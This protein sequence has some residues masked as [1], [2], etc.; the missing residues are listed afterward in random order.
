VESAVSV[1]FLS[2]IDCVCEECLAVLNL[3]W[4]VDEEIGFL[5]F[6]PLKRGEI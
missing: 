3:P 2:T 1:F 6:A 5:K 4:N